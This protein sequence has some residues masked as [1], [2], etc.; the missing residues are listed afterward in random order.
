[1]ISAKSQR[2]PA[3]PSRIPTFANYEE[4]AAFWDTHDLTD[5]SDEFEPVEWK[6]NRV[7]SLGIMLPH[8]LFDDDVWEA[9]DTRARARAIDPTL[10]IKQWVLDGLN[11]ETEPNGAKPNR[12]GGLGPNLA[13]HEPHDR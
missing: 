9:I 2:S 13:D 10:L 6:V 3:R 11:V 4:E 7:V 8:D 1:M 12:H 5:F